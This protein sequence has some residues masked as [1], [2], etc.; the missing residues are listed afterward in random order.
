MSKRIIQ[1]EQYEEVVLALEA[2]GYQRQTQV[3][4]S[5][6][7]L[8]KIE[9]WA[10]NQYP[11]FLV[12]VDD[13]D[14]IEVWGD[15]DVWQDEGPDSNGFAEFFDKFVKGQSTVHDAPAAEP[16][17]EIELPPNLPPQ[18]TYPGTDHLKNCR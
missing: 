13:N 18:E 15:A 6:G 12:T 4:D 3:I 2:N 16:A 9:R 17:H 10:S 7:S 5:P 11:D 14:G 1:Q 8:Y